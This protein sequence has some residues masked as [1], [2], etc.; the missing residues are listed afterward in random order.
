M[1]EEG[2]CEI[3]TCQQV[4]VDIRGWYDSNTKMKVG[5]NINTFCDRITK[6]LQE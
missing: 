5:A 1:H 4:K 2:N 3:Y 6:E